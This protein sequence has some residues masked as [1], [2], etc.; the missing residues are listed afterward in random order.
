M[1]G[2]SQ[3]KS[4]RSS[5]RARKKAFRAVFFWCEKNTPSSDKNCRYCS[6]YANLAR[7]AAASCCSSASS[8]FA[9]K[10][11]LQRSLPALVK[12][13]WLV[14]GIFRPT[15]YSFYWNSELKPLWCSCSGMVEWSV[16]KSSWKQVSDVQEPPSFMA[17]EETLPQRALK[18]HVAHFP[19]CWMHSAFRASV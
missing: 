11:D 5:C 6:I 4:A 15:K 10:G 9:L 18:I 2:I 13:S 14:L 1:S 19:S 8:S 12:T 7:L 16:L 17:P 3:L